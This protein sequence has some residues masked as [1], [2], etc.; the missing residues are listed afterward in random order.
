M[1]GYGHGAGG[2]HKDCEASSLYHLSVISHLSIISLSSLISLLSLCHLSSLY[3]LSSLHHLSSLYHLSATRLL[4]HVDAALGV[5]CHLRPRHPEAHLLPVDR[6]RPRQD[7]VV[8]VREALCRIT[9][10]VTVGVTVCVTIGVTVSVTAGQDA[11]VVVREVLC[12]VVGKC[13]L[14]E[15]LSSA[16]EWRTTLCGASRK[17][18]VQVPMAH[19][20][21]RGPAPRRYVPLHA[22][23]WR[24]GH[25]EALSPAGG[26]AA[27]VAEL[28]RRAIEDLDQLLAHHGHHVLRAPAAPRGMGA[29]AR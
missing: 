27:P 3:H 16:A 10:G 8:V 12:S 25:R 7:A 22:V 15:A 29:H 11:V 21:S 20:P 24:T 13:F 26:A 4:R 9:A 23:T 28:G 1:R 14:R 6:R 2:T 17:G 18:G 5:H 19:G